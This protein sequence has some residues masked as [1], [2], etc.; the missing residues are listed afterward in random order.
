VHGRVARVAVLDRPARRLAAGLLQHRAVDA[1]DRPGRLG[2]GDERG[3]REQPVARMI[4]AH[5]RLRGHD[6]AGPDRH[7]RL[8]VR[9]ELARLE[10]G[11]DLVTG[12][13][14]GQ[15]VR[16]HVRREGAHLALA[17]LLRPVHRDVGV[18]HEV[19]GV[20]A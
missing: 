3:G 13:R 4:P 20:H 11:Q 9:D 14:L 15:R 18:A 2:G 19:V 17:R 6:L 1:R 10:R 12:R 8:V 16:V 5:Q 7:D